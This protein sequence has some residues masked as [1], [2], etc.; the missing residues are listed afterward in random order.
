MS[1][2]VP[3]I[4][5]IASTKL[6][7]PAE[8]ALWLNLYPSAGTVGAIVVLQLQSQV[9]GFGAGVKGDAR[10]AAV[11]KS[12]PD[13]TGSQIIREIPVHTGHHIAREVLDAQ[14]TKRLPIQTSGCIEWNANITS[15]YSESRV[16]GREP[17]LTI[18]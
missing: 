15:S 5:A 13:F 4:A 11:G 12:S 1:I 14:T 17:E 6:Q 8:I 3:A 16:V 7:R 9:G 18:L 10:A 2:D